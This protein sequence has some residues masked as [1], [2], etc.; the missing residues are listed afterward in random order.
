MNDRQQLEAAIAALE[1]QRGLVG[2]AVTDAAL[3]PMRERLAGIQDHDQ[4][5]RQVT[6]LFMDVVGSTALS[7]QLDPEDIQQ[8]I[9]G[10]L[11]R[12][13]VI[14]NDHQ[15]RVLQYAG[16]SLLAVFGDREA[17]EDDPERAVRCGLEIVREAQQI[18]AEVRAASRNGDFNVRVGIHTGS[19][20]LGGGV[21]DA[22]TIRGIAV[23]IAARMEQTAPV[24]SVR[25]SH[26]TQKH[27]RAKFEVT[28]EVP[29]AVKGFAEPMRSHLVLRAM[30]RTFGTV[31]RGIEG[32]A[33]PMVGRDT[34]LAKLVETYETVRDECAL[35]LVTVS[36]DPGLGKTRLMVE[37]ER[38]IRHNHAATLRLQ[39]R[40]QPYSNSVPYGLLRDLLMR[41]FEIFDSDS[42]ATAKTKLTQG[43]AACLGERG[44]EQAS[45]VGRLIG[46]DFSANAKIIALEGDGRQIRDQAFRVMAQYLR[47]RNK[48]TGSPVI[49]LLDDLHWADDGSL[50][51]VT[52]IASTCHD[53][54]ILLLCLTRPALFE[55]RPLWFTGGDKHLR[56]DLAPLSRGSSRVLI[57][58][59]LARLDAV[60]PI[61]RDLVT[62]SAEGNPY[63]VE[64]LI[65]MMIDDGAIVA[66]GEHWHVNAERLVQMRVPSTLAGVLQARLDAL[67]LRELATLQHASVVGHVFWDEALQRMAPVAP[68]VLE[69]LMRRDLTLGRDTSTFEGTHEY[70]FKHHLLHKVTYDSVLKRDKR[71]RHRLTAEWLVARSAERPSEYHG[72]IAD[73]FE[74]AGDRANAILYLCKAGDDAGQAY[75]IDVALQYFD[76]AL[77][78]M[79]ESLERFNVLVRRLDV[80]LAVR[81]VGKIHE[82][83]LIEIEAL[84][85]ALNDDSCR[86]RA[87]GFRVT[88][89]AC[90]G[91]LAAV[92]TAAIKALNYA[93]ISGESP[94]AIRAH[95]QWGRTLAQAGEA[96]AAREQLEQGLTLARSAENWSGEAS[97]LEQLGRMANTHGRY[98]DARR[99]LNAAQDLA[100]RNGDEWWAQMLRCELAEIDLSI[101]NYQRANEQLL[102]ALG[103][104]RMI[105]WPE[106]EAYVAVCLARLAYMR[107]EYGEALARLDEALAVDP[108]NEE[109]D[110]HAGYQCLRAHVH[111]AMGQAQ[112]A[113]SCYEKS[114]AACRM[115]N[116]PLAALEMQAGLARLA[117]L[118]G[119]YQQA[120]A[121]I[122][123]VVEKLDAGWRAEEF[124][125]DDLRVML[126]CYE[127]L[128]ASGD[129][130]AKRFCVTANEKML[131]RAELLE[132][133]DQDSFLDNV[134]TNRAISDAWQ[135]IRNATTGAV[136]IPPATSTGG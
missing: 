119:D 54:R 136:P 60:P 25:I 31:G 32:V 42:Q 22:R 38:W 49:L 114:A 87:A 96:A 121:H 108:G 112:E 95:N 20:L 45:V 133:G 53:T 80:L 26:E 43:L 118:M 17:R 76:R 79:P 113:A 55:R 33:A 29:I 57:E 48:E 24:G 13:T 6:V 129:E 64:E 40:C 70:V 65:G 135:S 58:E 7:R 21:D 92:S 69:G 101:G 16:D 127:V 3:A 62:S 124:V 78:L 71:E 12:L 67:P 125:M 30:P 27:V 46:L 86:A 115:L 35:V 81:R 47:L 37:F 19:V 94:A 134:P 61:L 1:A 74:K 68:G 107:N 10:A 56:V 85:E 72:L 75:A 109:L 51:F 99:H 128:A 89:S 59:L 98:R 106:C 34:E 130:R 18:G 93:K 44:A 104:F 2:D 131:A 82:Q 23:N 126:T 100:Q 111:A 88:Y 66:E 36:G 9:D 14:V 11:R 90:L 28:D 4:S 41:H 97:A 117:M 84:A 120:K 122:A 116:R 52:H 39:G 105:G 50:D 103:A 123:P 8:I 73:H 63:F 5:L 102:V 77:A 83:N 15:G 91:D 132:S 110:F